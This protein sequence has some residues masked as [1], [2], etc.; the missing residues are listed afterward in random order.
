MTPLVTMKPSTFRRVIRLVMTQILTVQVLGP[1]TFVAVGATALTAVS[2]ATSAEPAK[3]ATTP[4]PVL[5]LEQN[6]QATPAE[7]A[8]LGSAGG[9]TVT[10]VTLAQWQAM[11]SAQ[12]KAY[13][14]LVIGD[15]SSGSCSSLMPVTG[16][17][18]A[19]QESIGTAWQAAVTG[20]VS[21]LGTAPVLPGTNAAS[22]LVTAGVGY[23]AS[24]WNS[25]TQT[26]T[27]LYVSLNCDYSTVAAGT[28]VAFLN[29]VEGIGTAGGLTV[30]GGLSCADPGTINKWEALASAT[31]DAV[32]ST[33]LTGSANWPSP[34]CPVEETFD[35]WTAM[36]T[37]VAY[38]G[39]IDATDNFTASDGVQG[40]PY[41]LLG[42]PATAATL[43]LDP[44]QGGQ[45]PTGATAGG[46]DNRAA[47]GVSQPS[48]DGVDTATGD[49]ST[50]NDDFSI[51]AFGPDLSFSRTYDAQTAQ[52]QTEAQ[53]P[54]PMGYGWTN[55]WTT[56]LNSSEPVP[57]DI[58]AISGL[59]TDNGNGGPP[60]GVPSDT[61]G[62][63]L[64]R[65]D[66]YFADI[67]N[68]RVMEVPGS[69]GTQWG[70]SMTAGDIYQVAG[71]PIGDS[72]R[73]KD[74]TAVANSLLT[75][76]DGVALDSAGDLYIADQGN[77]RVVEIPV[78]SGTQWGISMTADHMYNVA[79]HATGGGGHSGDAGPAV[80]A[81]LSAPAGL[82]FDPSG[83]LY[84][85][86]SLNSRI[87]EVFATGG[88]QWS[89]SMTAN[90]I[91]T[92][93]GSA[94]GTAGDTSTNG[95]AATSALLNTPDGLSFSSAGD[96][97]IADTAN[98]RVVEVPQ[99]GGAQWG[100][101]MS[102]ND[103]YT[104][105]G[106]ATG[107]VG[108]SGD[109]GAA[110]S[111]K[112]FAP[113]SV[114][115]DNGKQLYI[116]DAGNGEIREVART[117]HGEWNVPMTA[118]DIYTIAGNGTSGFSGNNGPALSAELDH[119]LG[120]ALNG[121]TTLYI[122][123][124]G[125]D[126]V[127]QV[128]G[129]TFN[130]TAFAGNGSSLL[131]VGNN[132]PALG[133]ADQAPTAVTTDDV[134]NIY[135]ADSGNQRVQE[136]AVSSHSQFGISMTAGDVYTVAGHANGA[137][138]NMGN[139]GPATAAKINDP[140]ALAVD[141]NGNLY[142]ADTGNNRIEEVAA[143]NGTQWNQLM[144][145]GDIYTVAG[146]AGGTAGI[147]GDGNPAGTALLDFPNG[148]AIDPAGDIYI[149]DSSN[150][151]IQEVA[152]ANGNQWGKSMTGGDIY[153]VAGSQT[154]H[155]GRTGDGGPVASALLNLPEAV[156][157]DAVG[158]VLIADS[159]NNRIQE[160]HATGGQS[161]GQQMT[162]GDMYTAAGGGAAGLSGDGGSATS[163]KLNEPA[164]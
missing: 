19:G 108:S 51:S 26:G 63:V 46:G 75:D 29:G 132:G 67:G 41:M 128:S 121:T 27:G 126:R 40:Q 33:M 115:L 153:T 90:D 133:A 101:S 48:A 14:A 25:G 61:P 164:A 68:N 39:A 65:N 131:S 49:Y 17:A 80:N 98:N 72:G 73:S 78:A 81:F 45:T 59:G 119:P 112:L 66:V 58:Y 105:A 47:P 3:A 160:M 116:A 118:N 37:P 38:D 87:Q 109:R 91:Y 158:D 150:S 152:S 146:D 7:D 142:I 93:A 129:T 141:S 28:S 149:S 55:N 159:L 21:M 102:A 155:A 120:L 161:F 143:A 125:N 13:A 16:T 15:P 20:N 43:A 77:N 107:V 57:G 148:V 64:W 104:V 53:D 69:S 54:G 95:M 88:Q 23:A 127:R 106:S 84:I 134:G 8:I 137:G 70:I 147:T 140:S 18:G 62:P 163:A 1:A 85:A 151:R 94:A 124:S 35:S 117:S 71:S 10:P 145:G 99:A 31:F 122:A 130:I 9:F 113:E 111:A 6:G 114:E 52:N 139:D 97:F 83:D 44:S 30:Q 5:V 162:S 74:G 56:A 79:G 32:Y 123:D 103:L 154:G 76:P 2:V 136:I 50:S 92:V 36:F 60:T 89:Q 138:G 12:F 42:S 82:A 110:V 156:S 144:T 24:S 34:S 96:L 135:V 86:D 157:T 100:I 11:T 4:L 22:G